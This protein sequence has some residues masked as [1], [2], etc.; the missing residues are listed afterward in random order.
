MTGIRIQDGQFISSVILLHKILQGQ[1]YRIDRQTPIFTKISVI[2]FGLFFYNKPDGVSRFCFRDVSINPLFKDKVS[3]VSIS[4]HVL[5][6]KM[7]FT[8][9]VC[10]CTSCNHPAAAG[11][12]NTYSCL[13]VWYQKDTSCNLQRYIFA[14]RKV[15]DNMTG[16]LVHCIIMRILI[17]LYRTMCIINSSIVSHFIFANGYRF[18]CIKIKNDYLFIPLINSK[19]FC[20]A[21]NIRRN[22]VRINVNRHP[23][24]ISGRVNCQIGCVWI[25]V[26]IEINFFCSEGRRHMCTLLDHCI[27]SFFNNFRIFMDQISSS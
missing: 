9:F 23:I 3:P 5:V 10:E 7:E 12:I 22:S 19:R 15:P 6:N 20:S 25:Y 14:V 11:A 13:I 21:N 24:W 27:N 26:R 4:R 17:R 1:F 2:L 18:R 16:N 8:G